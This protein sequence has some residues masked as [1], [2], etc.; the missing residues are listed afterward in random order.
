V[1]PRFTTTLPLSS[2][3]DPDFLLHKCRQR[4]RMRLS[5]KR[6]A[7]RPIKPLPTGNPGERRDP[8]FYRV[9]WVQANAEICNLLIPLL[10]P[11]IAH[12]RNLGRYNCLLLGPSPQLT[13]GFDHPRF[14]TTLPLSS[15]PDPDFLL[16]KCRQRPRMWLSAKRV[17][18][19]R[20]IKDLPIGN[21]GERR[22][23]QFYRVCWVQANAGIC[24]LFIPLLNPTNP[25]PQFRP[26]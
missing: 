17:A 10:A 6:V 23:P 3:P 7:S 11:T 24:N 2:R 4:P 26:L 18:S 9:R 15:R 20:P 13:L 8:Q 22:H 21:P 19:N 5:P 16:H 12:C 1:L 14:T 25:L